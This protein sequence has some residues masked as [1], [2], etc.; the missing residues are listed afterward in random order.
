MVS[1]AL[2]EAG[3]GLASVCIDQESTGS[4]RVGTGIIGEPYSKRRLSNEGEKVPV[5]GASNGSFSSDDLHSFHPWINNV[6]S[7]SHIELPDPSSNSS[8]DE[9]L[10][11]LVKAQYGLCLEVKPALSLDNFFSEVSEEQ[12]AAYTLDVV[13]V[14]R[15]NDL[16]ALKKLQEDGQPINCF[17]RF[18]ESLLNMACRR[19]F[20]SIVEYLLDQPGIDLRICDDTG[21]TPVHDACW[22]PSPQLNICKWIIERDPSLFMLSDNRGCTPFQYARPEHWAIWKQFLLDNRESL[23]ALA[24]SEVLTRLI[25]R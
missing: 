17:N 1:S 5:S 3:L 25:K 21:R 4:R 12:M 6:N 7:T 16:E 24:D 15:N 19:G 10:L 22:N 18:G 8:P 14:V 20:E 2:N 9:F 11:E 13:G 23:K